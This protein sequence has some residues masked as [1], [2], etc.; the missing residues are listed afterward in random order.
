MAALEEAQGEL[1]HVVHVQ[2]RPLLQVEPF[3][4]RVDL[5]ACNILYY[6]IMYCV[7]PY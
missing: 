6:V 1:G 2:L 3:Q 7:V 5:L 4:E